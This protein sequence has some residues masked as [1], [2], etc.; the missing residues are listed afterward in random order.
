M[1]SIFIVED[2]LSLQLI[3]KNMFAYL[4]F[5]VVDIASNG[6]DAVK[7][8]KSFLEK[9]DIIIMDYRFIKFLF[10]NMFFNM[11]DAYYKPFWDFYYITNQ[12]LDLPHVYLLKLNSL[13]F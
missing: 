2:E 6:R 12:I 8:Y 4:G 10:R 1:V 5:Q 3:Y 9:P 7:M 13:Y 11:L